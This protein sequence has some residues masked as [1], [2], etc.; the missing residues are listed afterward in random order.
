MDYTNRRYFL[1]RFYYHN[2]T[3]EKLIKQ[4]PSI[5]LFSP[6]NHVNSEDRKGKNGNFVKNK[7]DG[8]NEDI[9]GLGYVQQMISCSLTDVVG[10]E[11]ELTAL[12]EEKPAYNCFVELTKDLIGQ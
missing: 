12:H 1:V 6:Y 3:L 4:F 2:E 10:L 5:K 8:D 9:I 7:Y 11:D